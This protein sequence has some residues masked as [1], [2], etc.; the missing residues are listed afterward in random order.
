VVGGIDNGWK[1]AMGLLAYERGAST[2][3]QQFAFEGELR[4]ITELAKANG[5]SADHRFRQRLADAWSRLE[6]MRWNSL[7]MLTEADRPELSGPA[8]LSKLYWARLHRDLG[9]LFVDVLGPEALISDGFPYELSPA[10]RL[11]LYTRA[12]TIYGGSNE[13]QRNII[14]ERGLGLPPEPRPS[15]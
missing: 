15:P 1:V 2:L 6:I 5:R 14:G 11:F 13:I 7:R 9:E 8:Y 10:Q 4:E 3:G 12:D